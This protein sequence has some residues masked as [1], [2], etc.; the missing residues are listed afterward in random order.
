MRICFSTLACPEWDL[1]T[2]AKKGGQFR[3]DGVDFYNL[4]DDVDL[5]KL[6]AFSFRAEQTR[7]KLDSAGLKIVALSCDAA[8]DVKSKKDAAAQLDKARRYLDAAAAVDAEF[9]RVLATDQMDSGG[10]QDRLNRAGERL[11]VLADHAA[12]R[13][14]SV[15]VENSGALCKCESMWWLIDRV[16]SPRVG[17][18]WNP[19]AALDGLERPSK[20]IPTLGGKIAYF[21]A[22][23]AKVAT[24]HAFT[25]TTLDAG[26][27][28]LKHTLEVLKG[29]GYEGFLCFEWPRLWAR[30]LEEVGSMLAPL[31]NAD[32]ALP[33]AAE[34]LK[35][36]LGIPVEQV[37]AAANG[38]D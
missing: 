7:Q 15:V 16:G 29:V 14:V 28:D 5:P 1:D 8:F 21:K 13:R 19:V 34:S 36:W 18:C 38:D 30:K 25:P 2:I 33:A 27:L 37:P 26:D 6:P 4:G 9:V 10:T 35:G 24:N 3:Y 23:N 20:S 17:A 31:A 11:A 32:E 12:D 22:V